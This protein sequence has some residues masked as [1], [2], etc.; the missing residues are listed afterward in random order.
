MGQ[1]IRPLWL[2]MR[3]WGVALTL[4]CVPSNKPM[5]ALNTTEDMVKAHDHWF[6]RDP[7]PARG[8][9][10]LSSPVTS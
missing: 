8:L 9:S 3:F 10:D 5:W 4:R 7:N 1:E 2:G 6:D